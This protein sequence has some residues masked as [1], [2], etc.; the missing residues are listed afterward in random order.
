MN[1]PDLIRDVLVAIGEDPDREGLKD[2]PKRVVKSWADLYGG[3]H[4]KPADILSTVFE[5]GACD[6]MVILKGIPFSSMCEHHMLPFIGVAHVGY[7]P[8]GRVVGLS[9]LARLT[10]CFA[11]RLQI[12]EKMTAQIADAIEAHLKPRGTAVVIEAH[13]QCMS[14]RGIKKQGTVMVTSAMRGTFREDAAARAEVLSLM[15]G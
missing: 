8:A 2:T 15:R 7:L 6:E 12:Q 10:D 3:Y 9:K 4:Q 14:C 1:Y 5:D 13:H 11:K